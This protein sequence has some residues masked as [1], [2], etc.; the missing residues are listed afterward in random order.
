MGNMGAIRGWGGGWH[1]ASEVLDGW[2]GE[3]EGGEGKVSM[4]A[5]AR[6]RMWQAGFREAELAGLWAGAGG[7]PGE[8]ADAM[9]LASCSTVVVMLSRLLRC[10]SI[11]YIY[12]YYINN[13]HIISTT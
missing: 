5:R 1:A 8:L 9:Q 6:A 4:R 13:I 11:L 7:V 2:V 12:I 10:R 3:G